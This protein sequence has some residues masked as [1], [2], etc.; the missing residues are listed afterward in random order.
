MS[1]KTG[2]AS[3]LEV[4][5]AART[6][7]IRRSSSVSDAVGVIGTEDKEVNVL[8]TGKREVAAA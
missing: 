7:T 6:S 2:L 5:V 1:W 4:V 3:V 8:E